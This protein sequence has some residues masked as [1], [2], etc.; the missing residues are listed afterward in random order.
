MYPKVG[1]IFFNKSR[2]KHYL[3]LDEPNGQDLFNDYL[4]L[5]LEDGTHDRA[6]QMHFERYCVKVA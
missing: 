3:I 2:K 1:D 4:L 6:A 5:I